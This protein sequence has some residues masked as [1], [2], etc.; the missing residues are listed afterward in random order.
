MA[1]FGA[2]TVDKKDCL[3]LLFYGH[4]DVQPADVSRWDSPPF[5]MSGRDGYLY[6]RGGDV[7]RRSIAYA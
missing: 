5:V 3:N 2:S 6:G 4:Y 1:K 7:F